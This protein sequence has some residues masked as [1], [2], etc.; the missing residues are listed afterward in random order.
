MNAYRKKQILIDMLKDNKTDMVAL[1]ET[2]K[3][4]FS[5]RYLRSL[6][7]HIDEWE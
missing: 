7:S 4:N 6:S 1:Q 5:V 3:E 2:K